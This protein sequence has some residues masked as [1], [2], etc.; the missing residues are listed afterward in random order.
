M[1]YGCLGG[2][3]RG[4]LELKCAWICLGEVEQQGEGL[5]PRGFLYVARV[6]L[7]IVDVGCD[8]FGSVVREK[9]RR[10]VSKA[11]LLNSARVIQEMEGRA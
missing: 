9:V 3:R 7:L 1:E 5:F 10:V 11:L 2:G 4:L 8:Q 6:S